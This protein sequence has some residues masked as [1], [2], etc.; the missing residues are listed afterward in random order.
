[1]FVKP[2]NLI[3]LCFLFFLLKI[4]I[5]SATDEIDPNP[6]F[7]IDLN[8][9]TRLEVFKSTS[10]DQII[11]NR[12]E[13]EHKNLK[14][15]SLGV[16]KIVSKLNKY[17]TGFIRFNSNGFH[18]LVEF[19]TE[20]H[21]YFIRTKIYQ[22][23]KILVDE[24]QIEILMNDRFKCSLALNCQGKDEIFNGYFKN[25]KTYPLKIEFE[26]NLDFKKSQRYCLEDVMDKNNSQINFQCSISSV[27]RE[28]LKIDVAKFE[29]IAIYDKHFDSC[30]SVLITPKQLDRFASVLF[31]HL[32][33][34]DFNI[35]AVDFMK[36]FEKEILKKRKFEKFDFLEAL[37]SLSKNSN[38]NLTK[39]YSIYHKLSTLV[40]F[41]PMLSSSSFTFILNEKLMKELKNQS[42]VL[43][44][45]VEP[46]DIFFKKN[47]EGG[48]SYTFFFSDFH[49]I[50]NILNEL[51]NNIIEW[52]IIEE[53]VI[54]KSLKLLKI[55]RSELKNE[56]LLFESIVKEYNY[57]ERIFNLSLNYQDN[58][59]PLFFLAKANT[60][61]QTTNEENIVLELKQIKHNTR[62]LQEKLF[63]YDIRLKGH[64]QTITQLVKLPN[65]RVASCSKDGHINVWHSKSGRL[66]KSLTINKPIYNMVLMKNLNEIAIVSEPDNFHNHSIIIVDINKEIFKLPIV[67]HTDLIKSMTLLNNGNLASLSFDNTIKIW[68]TETSE[69]I[70]NIDLNEIELD[71]IVALSN[72]DLMSSST[73]SL[74]I[75]DIKN[76]S[77]KKIYENIYAHNLVELTNGKIAYSDG[78]DIR[79]M[80][81]DDGS[82]WKT[83]SG[84]KDYVN[85]IIALKNG[86]IASGSDDKTI[87]IWNSKD[88]SIKQNITDGHTK[89]IT[90]LC[91]LDD[92]MIASGS[93]DKSIVI[94]KRSE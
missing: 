46:I 77:I 32:N 93:T 13:N 47:P 53:S 85:S 57:F 34:S 63:R 68:N 84:H 40:N 72:G 31:E 64:K 48:S 9:Q 49:N 89:E 2:I 75:W 79:I 74:I 39:P 36:N 76:G 1:M 12:N 22:K 30:E 16:P 67:G 61:D 62:V 33:V 88:G 25:N 94:W 56:Q 50:S 44:E 4:K 37:A 54:P 17:E 82:I 86:Y 8:D 52:E 41:K 70:S 24:N 60:V 71:S 65:N 92:E 28:N 7:I 43:F 42:N 23:Y 87:I 14:W 19:L 69:L 10:N 45:F 20:E 78:L 80:L 11:T 83:L 51:P 3:V 21:K 27:S 18:I 15:Y 35:T 38:N 6:E 29:E 58:I 59:D 81:L 26:I 90:A 91:L 66:L 55:V 5:H 73:N